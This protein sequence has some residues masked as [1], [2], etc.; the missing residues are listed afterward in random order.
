MTNNSNN[1]KYAVEDNNVDAIVPGGV[2][3]AF[4]AA[5]CDGYCHSIL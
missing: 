2:T 3:I 1:V 5:R 4:Y